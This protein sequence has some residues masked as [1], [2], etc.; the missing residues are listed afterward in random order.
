MTPERIDKT[1]RG[2]RACATNPQ[3]YEDCLKAQCPYI[4]AGAPGDMDCASLLAFDALGLLNSLAGGR[5]AL[6][7]LRGALGGGEA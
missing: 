6:E 3:W 7:A 2:L 1:L 5:T 4:D